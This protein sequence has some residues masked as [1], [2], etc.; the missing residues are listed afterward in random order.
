MV[1]TCKKK[2]Q[3]KRQFSQLDKILIGFVIGNS[4]SLNVSE[5]ETLEQHT[6]GQPGD[7]ERADN[8]APQN[9]VIENN[10][11]DQITTAVGKASIV[12][13]NCKHDAILTAID[14]V[15]IRRCAIDSK[16]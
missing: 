1:W 11:E 6:N 16:M 7:F 13:K 3:P 2:S 9:Q 10:I 12:A 8:S 4:F 5:N 15:V 14:K